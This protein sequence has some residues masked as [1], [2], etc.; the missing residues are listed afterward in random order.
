MLKYLHACLSS[1]TSICVGNIIIR[2]FATHTVHFDLN[3]RRIVVI[4]WQVCSPCRH[5]LHLYVLFFSQ[6]SYPNFLSLLWNDYFFLCNLQ[7]IYEQSVYRTDEHDKGFRGSTDHTVCYSKVYGLIRSLV[8]LPF[9]HTVFLFE[10]FY[11]LSPVNNI[12][13]YAL[14]HSYRHILSSFLL[15]SVFFSHSCLFMYLQ[16]S[17]QHSYPYPSP[18]PLPSSFSCTITPLAH[19]AVGPQRCSLKICVLL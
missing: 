18:F 4:I 19:P 14:T 16:N 9:L 12:H 2:H 3:Y 17:L 6:S 11:N 7:S 5:Y 13:P 10:F 15:L 8:L 1:L